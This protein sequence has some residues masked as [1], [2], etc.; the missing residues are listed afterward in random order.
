MKIRFFSIILCLAAALGLS[1]QPYCSVR[2]FNIRD[3]LA[4]NIISGMGQTPDGMMWVSTWNG[5]SC[6]DGY[7]FTTFRSRQGAEEVLTSNRIVKIKPNSSGDVWCITY[8]QRLYLFD[9]RQCR[10]ICVSDVIR[11]KYNLILL[12]RNI[13]TMND[14]TTWVSCEQG[15]R[16]IIRID[17]SKAAV[18]E[19]IDLIWLDKTRLKANYVNKVLQDNDGRVWVFTDQGLLLPGT[20]FS[21]S[22]PIEYMQPMGGKVWFGAKDG[23]LAWWQKDDKQLHTVQLPAGISR[24]TCLEQYDGELLLGTDQGVLFYH[25]VTGKTRSVSVQHPSQPSPQVMSLH[26]DS[27]HRVWAFTQGSGIVMMDTL[28]TTHWLQTSVD[29]SFAQ[30][31]A[32][33][34][35]SLWVEDSHHTIWTIP[36]GGTFSYYDETSGT[37]VPYTLKSI[38]YEYANIPTINKFYLDSQRN[39]WFSSIHDLTLLNFKYHNLKTIAIRPN[40]E[41]RAVITDRQGRLWVGNDRGYIVVFD[42]DGRRLGYV[43][44]DGRIQPQAVPFSSRIYAFHEDSDGTMW[45]GAKG[46]GLYRIGASGGVSHYQNDTTDQWSLSHNDIYA[47]DR[48]EKGNLWVGTYGG[49]LNLLQERDGRMVFVNQQ[50]T[51]KNYQTSSYS[52]IRRI[53][54]NGKGTVILSTSGGLVTFSN[55]FDKTGDIRFYYHTHISGDTTSLM[56]CDVLQTCVTRSGRIFVATMG[57]GMQ[58]LVSDNLLQ[59]RLV[60]Q[61]LGQFSPDEGN[62]LA[63]TED[64]NGNL[65]VSRETTIDRITPQSGQ[66]LQFGPNDLGDRAEF[67]EAQP[68][69]SPHTG[70]VSMGVM[71]GIVTFRPTTI[72]KSSYDPRIV[73]TSVHFQGEQ[74][75]RPLLNAT[76][77]VIPSDKRNVTISFAALDYSNNYLVRYAYKVEG[78]DREWTY[79]SGG[80][81]QASFNQL[82]HGSYR[83]L[84]RSTNCD[85]VWSDNLATLDIYAKPTFWESIWGKLLL[86][87]MGI[88]VCYA[89]FRYYTMRSKAKMERELSDMKTQFFTDVSHRL[90][91]PLTLIG[92]PVR[93]V[94]DAGGLT[95]TARKHLEMVSRNASNM[96]ELVNKM[97]T[98]SKDHGVYI[99]DTETPVAEAL[100]DAEVVT[101]ADE[102]ETATRLSLL[103]VEDNADLREFLSSILS[104][105]YRVLTA[106]NGQQG[107]EAAERD[108]PDFIITDVMMPVMDGLTMVHQIKQNK[109]ICHIPIIVLSAKAS[110]EDRLQGL[111][112]G[113]DDYITKPFSAIYLKTRV[114]NIIAQRQLL[115]QSYLENYAASSSVAGSSFSQDE[116]AE[117]L[118]VDAA[119]AY[120]L[121]APQIVDA[122]QK[123]MKSLMAFLEQHVGDADLKIEE[124]A[125]AVNLSRSV[126]YGKVKAIVGMSPVDFLRHVRIQRAEEL[127][128]RSNYPVSQ[129]AY[130]VGFSDPKYFSKCFKKETGMT[131]SEYREKTGE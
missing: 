97:L 124:L 56:T 84:V 112:E 94:L 116:T 131:P 111:S 109:D 91:T 90:R 27:R 123:M 16:V 45:V 11:E 110:L 66:L 30:T 79:V 55:R 19:G 99:S 24:I 21:S 61:R 88:I 95:T 15:L 108:M 43:A 58:E 129:I 40:E 71:G 73:F 12:P 125:D 28:G 36:N 70:R 96:L 98:Y 60:L 25:P 119:T 130:A 117:T 83:L 77:L 93:E 17:E 31:T 92:G 46:G 115:Q 6:Y 87:L 80:I 64:G 122:D 1:A 39:L 59:D 13:Y 120:R 35:L 3:G 63:M 44:P 23:R 49:G 42:A 85:G 10:Y 29:A 4:A 32:D 81:H 105:D 8:D 62:V 5:L 65:W 103:V 104:D 102:A 128:K 57:G 69:Y 20:D 86:L 9:T 114:R 127:I 41:T 75:A 126:F 48:D 76:R 78:V 22:M 34:R 52:R 2:T 107:L 118:S 37:L 100:P 14:G 50:N 72:A 121:E 101:T 68:D 106:E 18:P 54:H 82:P 47:I 7:Q 33:S 113:I 51:F 67:S 74:E 89:V 26:I 38:G 53:T